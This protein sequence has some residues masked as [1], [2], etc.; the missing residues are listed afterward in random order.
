M[1]SS[2]LFTELLRNLEN[3]CKKLFK[4]SKVSYLFTGSTEV[5][6]LLMQE[7]ARLK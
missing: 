7:G 4:V 2:K 3:A 6:D 1:P 5:I